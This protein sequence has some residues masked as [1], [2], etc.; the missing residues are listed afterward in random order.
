MILAAGLGTRLKPWTLEHP[1]ALVPVDGVPMLERVIVKLKAQGYDDIVVNVHHFA[2]QIA[3]FIKGND[4]GVKIS[5]SDESEKLL[6]T[7]GG[8]ANAFNMLKGEP[9]LVHNVDIL[10]NADLRKLMAVHKERK[11]DVT[12]LT[13]GRD[14]SRKLLF[15]DEDDLKGWHNLSTGEFR[16]VESGSLEM[17]EENAFSGIYIVGENGLDALCRFGKELGSE[18]FPV[19]DFFLASVNKLKIRRYYSADLD[20]I[21]IGKPET[22]KKALMFIGGDARRNAFCCC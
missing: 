11:D 2:N 7:G 10:S 22:L 5:I 18:V 8:L 4:F 20:L 1:K 21:D 15:G 6:D 19:M 12:L 17:I 16:P 14:S 9:F 13:S 3:D